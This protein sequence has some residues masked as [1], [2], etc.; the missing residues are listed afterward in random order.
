MEQEQYWARI[1]IDVRCSSKEDLEVLRRIAHHPEEFIDFES[2]P[3]ICEEGS[4]TVSDISYEQGDKST[5]SA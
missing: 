2:W 4:I 1:S 5:T 3:E